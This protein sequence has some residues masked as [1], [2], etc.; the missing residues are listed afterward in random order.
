MKENVGT[1][2]SVPLGL[3]EHS[4]GNDDSPYPLPAGPP[5]KFHF[6]NQPHCAFGNVGNLLGYLGDI[7]EG[8][9]FFNHIRTDVQTLLSP[10]EYGRLKIKYR[11][12]RYHIAVILLGRGGYQLQKMDLNTDM[13]S[14][15]HKKLGYDG[16]FFIPKSIPS[17]TD[18]VISVSDGK[19]ID[20]AHRYVIDL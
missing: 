20:G 18:H 6:N 3:R 5:V 10:V 11:C 12:S 17:H 16:M 13:L 19:I 14:L 9:L 1:F 7:V 15:D 2:L 8:K 4:S